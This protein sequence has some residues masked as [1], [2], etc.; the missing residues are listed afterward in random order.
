L[1]PSGLEL[2]VVQ[3]IARRYIDYAIPAPDSERVSKFQIT[4]ACFSYKKKK[5][6]KEKLSL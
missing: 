1:P 4:P 5:K 6:K 3:P 2:L